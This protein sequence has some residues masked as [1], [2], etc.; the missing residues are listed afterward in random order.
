M[1]TA[2]LLAITA[3]GGVMGGYYWRGRRLENERLRE[4]ENPKD[5]NII[6]SKPSHITFLKE[7]KS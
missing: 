4:I 2:G 3:T 5:L 7:K 6:E 1:V